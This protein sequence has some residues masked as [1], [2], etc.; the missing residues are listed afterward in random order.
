MQNCLKISLTALIFISFNAVAQKSQILIARN[1]V[2]KLQA[3]IA[4][5]E[6]EKKQL[7]IITEGLK[8]I[9]SAE[10]DNK[11]CVIIKFLSKWGAIFEKGMAASVVQICKQILPLFLL[12]FYNK[13]DASIIFTFQYG[14]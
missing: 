12:N 4:N 7:S 3:S 2:G 14:K 11:T 1:A 9:E 10:K 13:V 6:D 5:K 8:S